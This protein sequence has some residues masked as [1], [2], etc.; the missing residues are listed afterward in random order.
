MALRFATDT[1][2]VRPDDTDMMLQL[3]QVYRATGR[4][5]E[6]QAAAMKAVRP[7]GNDAQPLA[8]FAQINELQGR[9]DLALDS[10]LRAVGLQLGAAENYLAAS[11]LLATRAASTRPRLCSG[12]AKLVRSVQ[13]FSL[14]RCMTC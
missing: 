7:S 11:R 9:P 8:E 10:Y 14:L 2:A 1:L 13:I 4:L 12:A 3:A 6:A 5:D